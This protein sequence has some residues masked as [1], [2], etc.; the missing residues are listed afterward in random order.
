MIE[1]AARRID[2][3]ED[4]TADAVLNNRFDLG[5]FACGFEARCATLAQSIAESTKFDN[6]LLLGFDNFTDDKQRVANQS[7]MYKSLRRRPVKIGGY[8]HE[9]ILKRLQ[10][11][12]PFPSNENCL[13]VL[14]DYSSMTKTMYATI[15]RY[16][17]YS[18]EMWDHVELTFSYTIGSHVE[19][20]TNAVHISPA[21]IKEIIALP[22]YEGALPRPRGT[23]AMF[24]LG[25]ETLKPISVSERLETQSVNAFIADP[26]AYDD[27]AE[28]AL[29]QNK[30]F[31]ENY[32]KKPPLRFPLRQ[33]S[34][35]YRTLSETVGPYVD[36]N[37]QNVHLVPLGPK[38]QV[39]AC[40]LVALKEPAVTVLQVSSERVK[41][42]LVSPL[43]KDPFVVTRI[44]LARR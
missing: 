33:P 22:G 23:I 11:A 39:L 38:P 44:R 32:L 36:Q 1:Y 40:L 42:E 7:E 20:N 28:I 3:V 30:E 34:L 24:G 43:E 31:I 37:Q 18:Q 41:P 12:K 9:T 17:F 26:G 5:I 15:L 35:L 27:Y 13:R 19:Y 4:V 6:C 14:I 21:S 29:Q 25:F 2:S 10:S 8:D 16:F